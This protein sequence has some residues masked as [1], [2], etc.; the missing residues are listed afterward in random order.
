VIIKETRVLLSFCRHKYDW[1]CDELMGGG[2]LNMYGAII[3]DLIAFLTRK[4]ATSVNGMLRTYARQTEHINGHRLI[5]SD[6]FCS[7]Q[8]ELNDD[9]CATVTVNGNVAG[10]YYQEVMIY[11]IL[12]LQMLIFV[13]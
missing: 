4:R 2:V 9:A 5:T 7:F 8:M 10:P 6:D 12:L 11:R 3:V 1:V 13:S